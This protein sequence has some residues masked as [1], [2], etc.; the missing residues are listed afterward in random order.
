M[1]TRILSMLSDYLIGD[2]DFN[3]LEDLVIPL[4]WEVEGEESDL[5]DRLAAE[6]ACVKDFT[7][8]EAEFRSR[9]TEIVRPKPDIAFQD[10]T[11]QMDTAIWTGLDSRNVVIKYREPAATIDHRLVVQFG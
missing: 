9:V 8:E 3:S 4:A 11:G 1:G 6:M 2:I 5:V 7:L 10:A